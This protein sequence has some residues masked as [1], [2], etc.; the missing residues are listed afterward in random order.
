MFRTL[1]L[2]DKILSFGVL[3]RTSL[4]IQG[5]KLRLLLWLLPV[6]WD[7]SVYHCS[8]LSPS[9]PLIFFAIIPLPLPSPPDLLCPEASDIPQ[10]WL[11]LQLL[12][13]VGGKKSYPKMLRK[14]CHCV[15]SNQLESSKDQ[16]MMPA[17]MCPLELRLGS[18][19]IQRQGSRELRDR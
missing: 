16:N 1:S 18:L 7:C 8:L 2:N 4:C 10:Q 5:L 15:P 13:N 3:D 11:F 9:S 12:I 14:V 6:F 19:S 17:F